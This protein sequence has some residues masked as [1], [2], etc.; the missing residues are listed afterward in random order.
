MKIVSFKKE[1]IMKK[2]EIYTINNEHGLII[3]V[4]E[5]QYLYMSTEG[6]H[7]LTETDVNM[8]FSSLKRYIP[9]MSFKKLS[10]LNTEN[11]K[12]IGMI[13]EDIFL[14][15]FP[16]S[17]FQKYENTKIVISD[18][19]FIDIDIRRLR[20]FLEENGTLTATNTE[21]EE[22]WMKFSKEKIFT[23]YADMDKYNLK[24]FLQ[25]SHRYL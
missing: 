18:S 21:L 10:R 25:C 8:L 16:K 22:A 5:K 7:S 15:V 1:R 4:N 12:Y 17:K 20:N 13:E 23:N 19:N 3:I 2:R 14:S 6:K 9:Y 24:R 11:C